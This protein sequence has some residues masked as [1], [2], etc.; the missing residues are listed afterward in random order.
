MK[1]AE[2]VDP[3]SPDSNIV[4]VQVPSPAPNNKNR[5]KV[6]RM[7]NKQKTFLI[8]AVGTVALA[9]VAAM[10]YTVPKVTS[11]VLN[12]TADTDD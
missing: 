2:T 10:A 12:H 5:K 3:K 1:F 8:A 11:L 7:T 9:V 4:R 6:N